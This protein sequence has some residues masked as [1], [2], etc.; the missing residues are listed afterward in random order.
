MRSLFLYAVALLFV[1]ASAASAADP[2]AILSQSVPLNPERTDQARVGS[3]QYRG[4]VALRSNDGRFGGFSDLYVN[5]DGTRLLA[6]SD[7]GH[8]L[9]AAITYDE[10]GRLAGL[11]DAVM[12]PLIGE[13]GQLLTGADADAE[14]M[15]ILPDGSVL[16]GFENNHRL[17]LY[18]AADPPFSARPRRFPPPTML[19]QAPANGGIEALAHVGSN[20]LAAFTERLRAGGGVSAAWVGQGGDWVPFAYQHGRGFQPTGASLMERGDLLVL[21]RRYTPG[22]GNAV[23]FVRLA[24]DDIVPG[25]R[26]AGEVIGAFGAPLTIDNF[27]GVAVRTGDNGETY[28]YVLSDDNFNPLQRTLLMLFEINLQP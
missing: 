7:E 5:F 2:I 12:G 23:R 21:E 14:A 28:I 3:L 19:D 1:L 20:F 6:V 11:T 13:D 26:V 9:Q 27:E 8:W 10:A 18:P 15:A 22:V 25:R 4:G 16:V 17:L 24:R